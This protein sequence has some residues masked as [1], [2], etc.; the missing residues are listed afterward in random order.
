MTDQSMRGFLSA[1]E[2][3]G[4][5][6]RVIRKVD[7]KFELGAVLALKDRGPAFLFESVA[8]ST[9]PVAANLL[10]SRDRFARAFGV[11]RASLDAHCLN[12]LAQPVHRLGLA[13]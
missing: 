4:E 2:A 13:A 8:G 12:A 10:V 7:P 11:T 1:M 5:L 6:Q 9:M 3:A